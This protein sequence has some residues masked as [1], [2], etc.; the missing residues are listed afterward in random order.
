MRN[1][2]TVDPCMKDIDATISL[3]LNNLIVQDVNVIM[4]IWI[5]H[6]FVREIE[7]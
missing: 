1:D 5:P 6:G 2:L 7:I 3:L 4:A